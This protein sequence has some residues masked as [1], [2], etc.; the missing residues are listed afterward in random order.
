MTRSPATRVLKIAAELL[1]EAT[2][3]QQMRVLCRT[4]TRFAIREYHR[5]PRETDCGEGRLYKPRANSP[6]EAMSRVHDAVEETAGLWGLTVQ[7][8]K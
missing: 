4:C 2:P 3:R 8:R 1:P 6:L 5:C 7:W